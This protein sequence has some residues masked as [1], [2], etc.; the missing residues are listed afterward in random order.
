[1]QYKKIAV[2]NKQNNKETNIL[3]KLLYLRNIKTKKEEKA[4][5]NPKKEDFISPFA[6]CD[7]EK[8]IKRIKDAISKQEKILIWG[9]FDCDG[10]TSTT[11][12][13][14]TLTKLGANVIKFIPD[15]LD[16]G[17]GLN[18]KK[19][20][21][22][23][24]KE[25]I[26]LVITV[27]CGISNNSEINLLKGFKIDTIITDH[28]STDG[29][30][31]EAF[32][33][34]NP[35]VKNSIKEDVAIQDITSLTY[36]SGSVVAYKLA[37]ALLEDIEDD[38][39]KN[40]ILIIAAIGAIA[41]VVP[42]LGE[43]R[44]IV[45]TALDLLNNKKEEAQKAIYR[46]LSK[47]LKENI[48]STDIAFVLAPRIN[49]AGRLYSA[50]LSFEFLNTE[51]DNKLELIIDKLDNYNTIRQAKCEETYNDIK[52]YLDKNKE[53][54]NKSAIILLNEN[55]HI[56]I[57]GI[58]ASKIVEEYN[59]PCFL[60]TIDEDNYA[61][62]SIRSNEL[63]NVYQVLKENEE[64]F[65][66][67][68]G[69]KL[70]GGFSFNLNSKTFEEVKNSILKTIENNDNEEISNDI[71]YTDIELNPSDIDLNLLD[72][73]NQLEP[74]GEGNKPPI[75]AMF[76][77]E[78]KDFKTIGKEN[79]HLKLSF[80]KD[81][82]ELNAIKWRESE[83]LIPKGEKCDI[84]FYPRLNSFNGVDNIQ[85]E[86]VNIY[87]EKYSDFKDKKTFKLFDHRKKT[88][89]LDSISTYLK[90][91]NPDIGIWAKNPKTKEKLIKYEEIKNN[92][93]I[94]NKI[95]QGIMFFDYPSNCAEL[96][97]ILQIVK[98]QKIH[99]MNCEIDENIENYIKQ[100]TGMIKYC[101]SKLNGNIELEKISQALGVSVDFIQTALEILENIASIEII[102]I[103]KIKFIKPFNLEEFKKDSMFEVLKEEFN[104][105]IEFKTKFLN[106]DIKEI[107]NILNC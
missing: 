39:L 91:K 12:L 27:D 92:F 14:K 85:L 17:H 57:I 6:F 36:N 95:H 76:D 11:I 59:K 21:N 32:A 67:F 33:I 31:P 52:D 62:C 103:D 41:D 35:Q 86:I 45:A 4:F 2:K 80:L 42:I 5:L 69:H 20:I 60:M 61:R 96:N 15:R 7:M 83:I 40:E 78:F 81:N 87:C 89:I 25:K 72:T 97:E 44:A 74:F 23:I 24:S 56:G 104:K 94:E 10:V 1:M 53:E 106:C 82:V 77:V 34:I 79:N 18:S 46:L 8:A 93:I 50:E 64:L 54:A 29:E 98:P 37:S 88:G 9:D 22:F 48:T 73:I 43:N 107:E 66:G 16:D 47:N 51:S 70:A 28:H 55:W 3:K 84:A 90:T 65:E 102:D 13:F 68:G 49:A 100:L 101:D 75:C 99:F 105:I 63:I 71:L 19:L 30:I 58:V 26:K 38:K